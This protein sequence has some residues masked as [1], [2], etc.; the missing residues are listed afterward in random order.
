MS[1]LHKLLEEH[2]YGSRTLSKELK[3]TLMDVEAFTKALDTEVQNN[4]IGK[5][6]KPVEICE[7]PLFIPWC[8]T[9][10]TV[11]ETKGDDC[12]CTYENN[13]KAKQRKAWNKAIGK[14]DNNG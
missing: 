13:L 5:D 9:C 1:N 4:V 3:L 12:I 14:G 7:A 6:K 2:S 8:K 10:D 11:L